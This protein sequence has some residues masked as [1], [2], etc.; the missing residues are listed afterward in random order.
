MH[1]GK[2]QSLLSQRQAQRI[3]DWSDQEL[4]S[5]VLSGTVP[6]YSDEHVKTKVPEVDNTLVWGSI[7]SSVSP[8]D[9]PLQGR[10]K[11]AW[12]T[13]VRVRAQLKQRSVTA[14]ARVAL[15]EAT[16]LPTFLWSTES[17]DLTSS[18]RRHITGTQRHMLG[19]ILQVPRRPS[20]NVEGYM[21][22]HERLVSKT[23]QT[24][25]RAAWG[26]QPKVQIIFFPWACSAS[27]FC[28][29][30]MFLG[31]SVEKFGAVG[32]VREAAAGQAKEPTRAKS[33]T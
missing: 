23:L 33:S 29:S 24:H 4:Q 5:Y 14:N 26:G 8:T 10:L 25:C 20:E 3:H 15:L 19:Y 30:A 22:R 16:I 27:S 21:K 6:V 32:G 31:A 7:V 28:I 18:Q 11:A 12:S 1:A 2:S 13:Y 9:A 17:L